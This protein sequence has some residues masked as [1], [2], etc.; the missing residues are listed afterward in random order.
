MVQLLKHQHPNWELHVECSW[1]APSESQERLYRPD[2]MVKTPNGE[3]FLL[4]VTIPYAKSMQTI[5]TECCN[6][7]KPLGILNGC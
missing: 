6:T 4:D 5:T 7:L 1:R 2:C 3:L